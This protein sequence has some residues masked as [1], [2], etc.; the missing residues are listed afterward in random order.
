MSN[1]IVEGT[2]GSIAAG[3]ITAPTPLYGSYLTTHGFELLSYAECL[4]L[5][6]SVYVAFLLMKAIANTSLGKRV[7]RKVKSWFR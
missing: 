2:K 7:V 6:G 3:G 4:Q 5:L 1:S